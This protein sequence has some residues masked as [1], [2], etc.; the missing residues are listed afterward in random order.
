MKLLKLTSYPKL[1]LKSL[2]HAEVSY[3]SALSNFLLFVGAMSMVRRA[4]Y[5]PES[6]DPRL[7]NLLS[8]KLG[9]VAAVALAKKIARVVWTITLV[10][11]AATLLRHACLSQNARSDLPQTLQHGLTRGHVRVAG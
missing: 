1:V 9:R 2:I 8:R 10:K 6:I 7:A 5:N 4:K 11:R 3:A